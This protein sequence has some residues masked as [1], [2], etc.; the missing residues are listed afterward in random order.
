MLPVLTYT[1]PQA[2]ADALRW[3]ESTLDLAKE[4][5]AELDLEGAAFPWRTIRGQECSATGR[6]ERRRSMSTPTSRWRSSATAPSPATSRS[7]G[8]RPRGAGRDGAAVDSLGHHDRHG[9]WHLD[10]VTGPDEYTAVVRD[11]VFTNLMA[12]HNLRGA[13]EAAPATRGRTR[14]ASP[15]RRPPP[16]A[17]RPTPCTSRTTRSSASTSSPRASPACGVGLQGEHELPAAAARAVLRLY[18]RRWSSRPTWSWR[19]TG[20]V[21]RS[22]PSRRPATSTT[23]SGG[24]CATRRCRR[25][26]R[27]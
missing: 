2:A 13:A 9:G 14:W 12:A 8:V 23:T 11:N 26:S 19:C 18:R 24:P 15:P 6:P 1:Q 22:R 7:R 16:G 21:T 10:G 20:G 17:M 5:A 27:R 25:A 4:R 3:R